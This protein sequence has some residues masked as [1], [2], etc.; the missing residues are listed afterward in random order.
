MRI[1][2]LL[3]FL[4]SLLVNHKNGHAGEPSTV[5]SNPPKFELDIQP[6][7][8]APGCNAGAC[9]GKSRGKLVPSQS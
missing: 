6:I 1:C 7:L 8:T 3:S 2:L 9:H 4:L 5:E